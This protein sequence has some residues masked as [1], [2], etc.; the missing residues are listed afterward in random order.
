MWGEP[1]ITFS[2]REDLL[3]AIPHPR[4][5]IKFMPKWMHGL[6]KDVVGEGGQ[7]TRS[8]KSCVPV[9]DAISNGFIIPLWAD[10]EV[11][12]SFDEGRFDLYVTF[13]QNILGGD[14]MVGTHLLEQVG[15]ES[16]LTNTSLHRDPMKLSNPWSIKTPAGYSALIKAP[17]YQT[18]NLQILEGV[19]DTD[20]F[21]VEV[22]LPF[23]W[24][25]RDVGTWIIPKGTPLA[26]VVPFKRTRGRMD[27]SAHDE[28]QLAKQR[29][30]LMTMFQDRYRR[31]FWHKRREDEDE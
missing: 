23:V 28:N 22:G 15:A 8:V 11:T 17:P 30:T 26:Q 29:V 5:A 27:V 21:N 3:G 1:K 24:T 6:D 19:V 4:P 13:P 14:G 12:L 2:T 20:T 10:L 18:S 31:A 25:G 7:H 16:P 9:I